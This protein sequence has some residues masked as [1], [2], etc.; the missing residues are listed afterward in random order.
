VRAASG[1]ASA[2][3]RNACA[4]QDS[5]TL[6]CRGPAGQ[7]TLTLSAPLATVGEL[8]RL[9]A[10]KTGIEASRLELRSGFPPQALDLR[11]ASDTPL[12]ALNLRSGDTVQAA[13]SSAGAAAAGAAAAEAAP[14][15][16]AAAAGAAPSAPVSSAAR[17]AVA[18][19]DGS[20]FCLTRRII[21]SDNSCLFNAVGYVL[22][23][24]RTRAPELRRVVADAVAADEETF[25]EAALGRGNAEYCRWIMERDSWGGALELSILS[26]HAGKE[27][28][29]CDIQTKRI[30]MYG[31]G[32]WPER[33]FLLYDGL[34]YDALV[35]SVFEGAPEELDVTC[36]PVDAPNA[37][38]LDAAVAELVAAAHEARAFTDTQGFTLR[39]IVCRE[40]VR[41]QAA[42]AAHAAKTGHTNFGEYR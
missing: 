30:D 29:A 6:R 12:A 28:C 22:S 3:T 15:G 31:H 42:A 32:D 16:S 38:A 13:E 20:G 5:V 33:V 36:H 39:C 26:K 35:V 2:D 25:C 41:G 40:G 21:A 23:L 4:T 27:I 18:F 37:A 34:H 10:E 9:V 19:A 7:H 8:V 24:S 17:D 11:V 14:S 1:V